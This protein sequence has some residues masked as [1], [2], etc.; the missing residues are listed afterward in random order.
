MNSLTKYV[1]KLYIH[2][3]NTR[4]VEITTTIT[5]GIVLSIYIYIYIHFNSGKNGVSA[6]LN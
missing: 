4:Y 6:D 3:K 2:L 1:D 5:P